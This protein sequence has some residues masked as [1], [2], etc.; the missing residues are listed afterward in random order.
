VKR[1]VIVALGFSVLA[2]TATAQPRD[3]GRA[4]EPIGGFYKN[5]WALVI[6]INAY[7][8]VSPR[9]T[10][11]VADARA[12]AEALPA[13]GFPRQNIRLLLDGE[14]TKSQI[15]RVLYREFGRMG[16]DDRLLVYFA[17]HGETLAIRGGEEGYLLPVD[18]DPQTLPLTAIPMDDVK[19]ISQ[20]L[21]GKHYLFLMDACFSGFAITRDIAP[22]ATTDEYVA[23]AL[24]EPAVQILT[25]GR[26]GERSIEDGGHGLFTRRL[27]DGL[28]G[29]AFDPEGGGILTA[30]Q[31]AAWIEPRVVRDS[32]GRMNPQYGK[33]D[34]EG[35]FVF[36]KPG[37]QVALAPTD[38]PRPQIREELRRDVGTLSIASNLPGIEVLLDDQKLGETRAGRLLVVSDLPAKVYRLVARK[39]GYREWRR[40]L[41][42]KPDTRTD[43][44][45][46]L[47][48]TAPAPARPAIAALPPAAPPPPAP[49]VTPPGADPGPMVHV[50]GGPFRM[51][52]AADDARATPPEKPARTVTLGAFWIDQFEVTNAQYGAFRSATRYRAPSLWR[53]PRFG[54]PNQPVVAVTWQDAQEYCR[55]A[56]KR[57]PT[58][59]EWEKAARGT[60]G[61]V[62]PWG[63]ER[64]S[65]AR[66]QVVQGQ[67]SDV[68]QHPSGA[69]PYGAHD[70]AGNVWEWV[71]DWYDGNAYEKDPGA[72]NP[73]GPPIG[74]EKVLRG[75]SW[76]ERDPSG[77]RVTARHHQPPD[78]THNNVGFRCARGEPPG[79]A[80]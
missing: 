4:P 66:A 3:S 62:F 44:V 34:G 26:K 53:D 20:R 78:R 76:W 37:S 40:D 41:E 61:R 80:P 50:P 35:H 64:F 65:E 55:W 25:A 2:A 1:A 42:V 30:A 5:S 69:S 8:K 27:L 52:A 17:G 19:R 49:G 22:K 36:V 48:S 58:E 31:L 70:L 43:A 56:G 6:G 10:Y 77:V 23:S 33:I 46:D 74:G 72:T 15:E 47:E 51:G 9:L 28:R 79:R 68:G 60:D 54:G 57:L 71:Q 12:V 73:K 24:R 63:N 16:A 18:T 13:L 67:T 39:S 45:I 11:A 14:A 7:E 32:K 21:K 29:L 59:A 38:L 75:G